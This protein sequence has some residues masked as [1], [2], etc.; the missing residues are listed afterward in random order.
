MIC[1][2]LFKYTKMNEQVDP[3][4]IGYKAELTYREMYTQMYN[5]DFHLGHWNAKTIS[6]QLRAVFLI[7]SI[8]SSW[9]WCNI[10]LCQ[11]TAPDEH[12]N[13][14][15]HLHMWSHYILTNRFRFKFSSSCNLS[16]RFNVKCRSSQFSS[17]TPNDK[18]W[19]NFNIQCHLKYST[20]SFANTVLYGLYF[21]SAITEWYLSN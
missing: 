5:W 9:N 15:T 6:I 13:R 19:R 3:S 16:V 8:G 10:C 14:L 17:T 21:L 11:F 7:R 12:N 2:C 20:Y 4:Y 1:S 18:R